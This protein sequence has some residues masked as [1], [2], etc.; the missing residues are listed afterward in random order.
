MCGNARNDKALSVG[1][2]VSFHVAAAAVPLHTLDASNRVGIYTVDD[3]V[4]L[5][6]AAEQ[7]GLNV[8]A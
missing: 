5:L 1:T 7:S 8:V 3:S 2:A 6:M 4:S